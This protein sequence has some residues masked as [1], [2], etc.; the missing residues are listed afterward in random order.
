MDP[1]ERYPSKESMIMTQG[2]QILL[3]TTLLVIASCKPEEPTPNPNPGPD[4]S[5]ETI[6]PTGDEKF[7]NTQSEYIFDQTKLHTFELTLPQA[8]LDFLDA[9]PAREQYVEGSLT[10][11]GETISPVGIRYKGSIGGFVGCVS[12]SDWANPSGHKTCPKLSMKVKINWE[13]SDTK[14]Y[15]LKKLQFHSMNLD[16]TQMRD[17]LGYHLFREMGVPAPRAVHARL[18]IN[19]E[20]AGLFALVEQIDGRFTRYNFD[21][22]EG[23]L[24]KEIWPIDHRGIP[25]SEQKYL[26]ALETNED[27]NPSVALIRGFGQEIRDTDPSEMQTVIEKWMDVDEI[28]AYAVVDRT[29][30][31]DDGA[32]HWYCEWL[33]SSNHNYFW[34]E[35]PNEQ[36]LH[37]IPWDIDNAFENIRTHVNPVTPIADAWGETRNDCKCFSFGSFGFQQ[38]SA[39]CDKLIAGWAGYT[40]KYAELK[41]KLI[42]GPMAKAEVEALLDTWKAQI[43]DATAEAI[44]T[45]PD[46]LSLWEWDAAVRELKLSLKFAREN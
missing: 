21:D 20:Y 34:Y 17:R 25:F 42:T 1:T 7:L 40:E 14:F 39:A 41:D 9:D 43:Q 16:P 30:R 2:I 6:I 22:G 19:G 46:A 3:L 37:L 11:E 15:K 8:N 5:V 28:I 29:I 12:G 32:F 44:E 35:E 31:N 38:R 13:G 27:E 26:A 36:K 23:N 10:F 4:N 18:I 24:Y 45:H 33:G